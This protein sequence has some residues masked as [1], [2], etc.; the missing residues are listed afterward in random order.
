MTITLPA[1]LAG[2]LVALGIAS[3]AWAGEFKYTMPPGWRDLLL[4]MGSQD[5]SAVPP[6]AIAEASSGR[7]AAYAIDPAGSTATKTGAMFNAVEGPEAGRITENMV[8]G[9]SAEMATQMRS[10]GLRVGIAEARLIS[11]NGADVGMVTLDVDSEQGGP[12]MLVQ[13]LMNGRKSSAVLT[14]SAPKDE[15]A[16]YLPAFRASAR[17]TSGAYTPGGFN[18]KQTL[19]VG[20]FAGFVGLVIALLRKRLAGSSKGEALEE[21]IRVAT[22]KPA[23]AATPPPKRKQSYVWTCPGCG[24]P[25]PLRIDQ[26]RCGTAKPA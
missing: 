11:M 17:A 22:G 23:A 19:A 10:L 26:C 6:Q 21:A 4:T 13:F 15:Y 16:R 2:I 25:V 9:Y 1:R 3:G 18:W 20:A 12:R 14:Y 24:N 8:D 7:F 5:T